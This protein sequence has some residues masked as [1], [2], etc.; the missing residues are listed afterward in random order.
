MLFSFFSIFP[1]HNKSDVVKD[2][3][4]LLFWGKMD[5]TSWHLGSEFSGT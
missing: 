3:D 2:Y 4:I 5:S 1:S